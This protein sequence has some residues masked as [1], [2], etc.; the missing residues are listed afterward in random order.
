MIQQYQL[1]EK[2]GCRHRPDG[3]RNQVL[4]ELK[5]ARSLCPCRQLFRFKGIAHID[6]TWATRTRVMRVG[7][8]NM[9]RS[10]SRFRWI[11]AECLSDVPVVPD[12]LRMFVYLLWKEWGQQ[13]GRRCGHFCSVNTAKLTQ[14]SQCIK[15]QKPR[16][17]EKDE[18]GDV[19]T[20][21]AFY[22]DLSDCVSMIKGLHSLWRHM[23]NEKAQ[24][25]KLTCA[26]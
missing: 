14:T 15:A 12:N 9:G 20:P 21:R 5:T 18:P 8:D 22:G 13:D 3:N 2:W 16:K 25:L 26:H 23:K 17:K 4:K 11:S 7:Y 6:R 24:V 10:T 1:V 19:G